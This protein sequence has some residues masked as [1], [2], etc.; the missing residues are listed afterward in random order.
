MN[1]L[2]LLSAMLMLEGCSTMPKKPETSIKEVPVPVSCI[3][4]K[5]SPPN[6][7]HDTLGPDYG[8]DVLYQAALTDMINLKKYVV[9]LETQVAVCSSITPITK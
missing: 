8:V 1:K 5:A 2:L 4:T 3:T 6:L 9:D 7:I